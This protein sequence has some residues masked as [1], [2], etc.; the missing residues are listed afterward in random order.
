[1]P[2]FKRVG[3]GDFFKAE[4][5]QSYKGRAAAA[6]LEPPEEESPAAKRPR[7]VEPDEASTQPSTPDDSK[8]Q[9]SMISDDQRARME[10]NRLAALERKQQL[11]GQAGTEQGEQSAQ[12]ASGLSDEARARIEANRLAALARKQ[13]KEREAQGLAEPEGSAIQKTPLVEA[14][15]NR[16]KPDDD[17]CSSSSVPTPSLSDLDDSD[18]DASSAQSSGSIKAPSWCRD[19]LDGNMSDASSAQS[20]R[21]SRKSSSSPSDSASSDSSMSDSSSS[22]SSPSGSSSSSSQD[23]DVEA[24]DDTAQDTQQEQRAL[25][26]TDSCGLLRT[27]SSEEVRATASPMHQSLPSPEVPVLES[28]LTQTDTPATETQVAEDDKP[29]RPI[30]KSVE[31]RDAKQKL[32]AQLLCRWWFALP[33]WPPEDFDSDVVLKSRGFRRV[34]LN[35]FD[36]EVEL[37][38]AGLRKAYELEQFKACFRASDG[39]LIDTRPIEGRPSWDQMMLKSTPDLYRLLRT[40]YDAQLE[41]LVTESQKPGASTDLLGHLDMLRKEAAQVRQKSMFYLSF[42]PKEVSGKN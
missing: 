30:P 12:R 13:Q 17:A 39:E 6:K 24:E 3:W 10:Q 35:T 26:P 40:A 25:E 28:V 21:S 31:E 15:V 41:E 32:V 9:E 42:K 22:E 27:L 36:Q 16:Q 1:M 34:P 37:D 11:V 4:P 38:E 33:P 7:V 14:S 5:L 2:I 8:D 18:D 20:H 23:S 29:D 19:I